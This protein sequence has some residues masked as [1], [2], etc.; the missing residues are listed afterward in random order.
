MEK[1]AD[2]RIVN[3]SS[4]APATFLP[5]DFEFSFDSSTLLTNP[6][7]SYPKS[8][9]FLGRFIFGFDMIR[10]SISK[11][12]VALFTQE[13]QHKLDTR[14]LPILSLSVHPGGGCH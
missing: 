2:V 14:E 12:G 5:V 13:L 7:P 6:V 3:I 9:R 10:Y 1:N 11:V 4:I 8:W